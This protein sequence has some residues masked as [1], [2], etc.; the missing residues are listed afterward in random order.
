LSRQL[1]YFRWYPADAIAD[2]RYSGLSI[3][4]LGLFHHALNFAWMNNGLPNDDAAIG[5]ALHVTVREMRTLWPAVRQCFAVRECDGKLINKRQE[6]E[7]EEALV[8]SEKARSS[9]QKRWEAPQPSSANAMPT[10]SEGIARAYGSGS[11]SGSV[12]EFTKKQTFLAENSIFPDWWEMWSK[13][14]GTHHS[15]EALQAWMSVVPMP[16]EGAALECT[17]SYLASLDNPAKGFNPDTFLFAQAKENFESRWPAF[18]P[19][20]GH[21]AKRETRAQR[22]AREMDE[23]ATA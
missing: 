21:D 1:P 15:R 22:L 14:R 13:V 5:R 4:E 8:V 2:F 7:R 12:F 19:R 23:A 10:H 18:A 20:N 3:P 9:A 6:E 11:V 17:A 16:L